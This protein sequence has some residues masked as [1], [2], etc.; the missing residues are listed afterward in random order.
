MPG[1]AAHL[2]REFRHAGAQAHSSVGSVRRP[3]S[4]IVAASL[5][6]GGRLVQLGYIVH[7]V[8]TA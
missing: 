6:D 7:A 8:E 5:E 1:H 3:R 2:T 4:W